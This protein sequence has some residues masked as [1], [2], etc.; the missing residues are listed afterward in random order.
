[1]AFVRRKTV[2]GRVYY[3][4]VECLW[5]DGK[6]RQKL[7]CYLGSHTTVAAAYKYWQKESKK[8]GRKTQA[9][10]MLKKLKPFV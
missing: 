10:K 8:P 7:I 1:M 4:L 5:V 2:K 9:A 3:Q 6:P